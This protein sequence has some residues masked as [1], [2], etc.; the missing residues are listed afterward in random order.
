MFV[1]LGAALASV[2]RGQNIQVVV[3]G[4]RADDSAFYFYSAVQRYASVNGWLRATADQV[5]LREQ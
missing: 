1:E 2:T 5:V 3:I 4:S